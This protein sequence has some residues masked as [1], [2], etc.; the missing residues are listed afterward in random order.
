M[1]KLVIAV[2]IL[3]VFAAVSHSLISL[4]LY[5]IPESRKMSWDARSGTGTEEGS[6]LFESI[7]ADQG[8]GLESTKEAPLQGGDWIPPYNDTPVEQVPTFVKRD[9]TSISIGEEKVVTSHPDQEKTTVYSSHF[10]AAITVSERE[11]QDVAL[12]LNA[13]IIDQIGERTLVLIPAQN[14]EV[15]ED[16]VQS[17]RIEAFEIGGWGSGIGKG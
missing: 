11:L 12:D 14:R 4:E 9:S 15:L 13:V 17:G 5:R 6:N 8:R 7:T 2:I 1:D 16:M 10:L 3:G